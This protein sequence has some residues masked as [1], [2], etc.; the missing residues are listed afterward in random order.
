MDGVFLTEFDVLV[1]GAGLAGLSA[2]IEAKHNGATVCVLSLVNPIRSHSTA[3]QGGINAPLG[4]NPEGAD[5]SVERHAFDTVKGSDYLADQDAVELMISKAPERIIELERWGT[6]FSRFSDGKIAQRPFGGAG[7]PRTCFAADKTGHLIMHTLY[8]V[9]IR[10]Q[11]EIFEDHAVTK[12]VSHNGSVQGV[13]AWNLVTGELKEFLAKSV[14]VATGGAGRIFSRTTN[15]IHSTGLGMALAFW[16][17]VGLKD[18]E[19]VQ[20]HPTSLFGT[21]LLLSEAARGEG[22]YLVNKFGER[23]M[24]RYAPGAMELAPRDIVA[25]GIQTEV[26]EGRGIE[27]EFV[28][29]DLR[30]LGKKRILER[31]PQIRELAIDFSG[32]DMITDCIPIQPAQH[33]TMGGIDCDIRGETTIKGLF[34]AGEVACVSV[35]GAN[36]LGGNSLLECAVYGKIAGDAAANRAK[37]KESVHSSIV[38]NSFSQEKE[39]FEQLMNQNGSLKY[40][41]ISERL[42]ETMSNEVGIF[43]NKEDL[44]SALQTIRGL[45]KQTKSIGLAFAETRFNLGLLNLMSLQGMLDVAEIIT[46]GALAREESRGGHFRTDFPK[47]DDKNWLKHTLGY[48]EGEQRPPRLEYGPVQ[49]TKWKPK[50]R[51]Y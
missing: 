14:V 30:H 20:F 3:A 44:S 19:F 17:G 37:D 46:L 27:D 6:P 50:A 40:R 23:F 26:N 5:D 51:E 41:E 4:N 42:R 39:R 10:E 18:M 38:H 8:E 11:I 34:A 31:L 49:I 15:S 33:Y 13:I 28:F 12:I 25:R 16:E 7:F 29:L 24:S 2:A 22:G 45:K 21:N 35:H 36:R 48:Y 32:R 43:R 1:I 47:R 9:A